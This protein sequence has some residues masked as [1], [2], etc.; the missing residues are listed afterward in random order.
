MA[1][2]GVLSW[3]RNTDGIKAAAQKKREQAFVRAE[4][5]I[6]KLL[7]EK[8]PINFESVAEAAVVTRAWLYRQPELRRRIEIL[9]EQ[10]TPKKQLPP[11]LRA[12]DASKNARITELMNQNKKLRAE[13]YRLNKQLEDTYGQVLG[14]DE[15]Q[16]R[17]QELEKQNHHLFNLLTQ[18]RAENEELLKR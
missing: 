3:E 4:E 11:S 17:N 15:L 12:S 16:A 10:Q 5:A 8:Q 18:V 14:L 9:R 6:K 7:R 1:K 13:N 2:E